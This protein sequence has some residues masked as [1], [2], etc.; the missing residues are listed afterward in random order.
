MTQTAGP[1][2]V[3]D[4]FTGPELDMSRWCYLQYPPGPD[5]TAWT[6]AEP[7][8]RTQ[9]DDGTLSIHVER[10]ERAHDQ[11]QIMDNPKHLLLSTESFTVPTGGAATF[12]MEMA[13]TGINAAPRDY[14][15]GFASMNVLDM[16]SGWVFDACATGDTVF[17]I[18]ERLPMPG[19]GRPFTYVIEHPLAGL[20]VAPGLA[21]RYEITLDARRGA[22]EWRVDGHLVHD[23]RGVEIPTRV[24][25]GLGLITLHP[26]ADGRS[27][28]L[29]G[30]GLSASFGP[31]SV[32]VHA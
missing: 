1:T 9:V 30:Q 24:N 29:R 5:G 32:R 6:C 26:V 17:S 22:A 31:I 21:H 27:R 2:T 23:V 12:A 19:V 11:V 13:A 14:R 4:E 10:F 16:A 25:V 3:Y 15:D 20:E 28:S 7:G 8:A 18:Y